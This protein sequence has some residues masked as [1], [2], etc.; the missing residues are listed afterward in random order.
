MRTGYFSPMPPAATGVADY[1][2]ALLPHLRSLGDIEVNAP[3]CD[4]ALYHIGNNPLHR[5]IY[6]RALKQPGV[7]VLH[8]AVLN[9]FF[10]GFGSEEKYVAEFVD[11]YGLWNE[12]LAR[13]L[14]RTRARSGTDPRYFD[15]PM[16][17][18]IANAARAVIVHNPAAAAIVHKHACEARI[19]E[20][21]HLFLNPEI[22]E[23]AGLR[24]RLKIAKES[25]LIGAFGH[26]RETKRLNVLLR[27][28]HKAL[29]AGAN[30][31]LLI[32]GAFVSETYERALAPLLDDKRI[33]RT[34]YLPEPE[35]WMHAAVTDLVVNLR[36][37]TAAE[38]SGIAISMM[39]IGKPVVF[40]AGDEI[41]RFPE[42]ACLR[43]ETGP[44][45]ETTLAEYIVWLASNREAAEEIG[46]RAAAYVRAEHDAKKV[47]RAYWTVL[48]KSLAASLL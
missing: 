11:N 14:W 32:S 13:E 29:D 23:A 39:G 45:E 46:R 48:E 16:L 2:A 19:E 36:Y 22:P 7:I 38:T 12:G 10:L 30:V 21:P 26:Q 31:T 25:L 20:I 34:G 9:H 18:S 24:E 44:S 42:N 40:S 6:E 41:A 27:A 28:F 35:F 3:V 17:K 4:V 5:E 37:P 47:A 8:D 33:V 1:S 43:L 15:Y